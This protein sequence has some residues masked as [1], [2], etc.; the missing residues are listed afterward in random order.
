MAVVELQRQAT[1]LVG[2][3][4]AQR[5][6][7]FLGET[8][9]DKALHGVQRAGARPNAEIDSEL[10]T[11]GLPTHREGATRRERLL[12][13][14]PESVD[15]PGAVRRGSNVKARVHEDGDDHHAKTPA[16]ARRGAPQAAH[17]PPCVLGHLELLLG[18]AGGI[19]HGLRIVDSA[20]LALALNAGV[21]REQLVLAIVALP[22]IPRHAT[23]LPS[24]GSRRS[25][26]TLHTFP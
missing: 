11:A 4:A 15:D 3:A 24:S 8:R 23:R 16:L 19:G 5:E 26:D 21:L 17:R 1:E 20:L 6:I 25:L 9:H 10:A 18:R 7:Q 13:V 12:N 14:R 2:H 22:L